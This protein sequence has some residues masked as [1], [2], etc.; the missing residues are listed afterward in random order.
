MPK[1]SPSN[2]ISFPEN[3]QCTIATCL[4]NVAT[5]SQTVARK[6]GRIKRVDNIFQQ[7]YLAKGDAM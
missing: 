6:F 1:L 2:E 3:V 4:F 5:D 7:R